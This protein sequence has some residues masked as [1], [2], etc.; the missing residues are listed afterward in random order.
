MTWTCGA[1]GTTWVLPAAPVLAGVAGR[2]LTDPKNSQA[3][4][5][6]IVSSTCSPAAGQRWTSGRTGTLSIN[7]KCLAVNGGSLLDGAAVE[8]GKCMGALSEQ[9]Q[10]DADGE[11]MNINSGRCLAD[12]NNS[13]VSGTALVQEDCYSLTGEIWL[14]T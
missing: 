9:W 1:S 11:L 4:G 14:I 3:G 13:A 12:P 8:I 6:K 10:R 5:T 7:G 2:C